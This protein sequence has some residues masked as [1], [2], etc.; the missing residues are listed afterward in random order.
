MKRQEDHRDFIFVCYSHNPQ[1]DL[2]KEMSGKKVEMEL[3]TKPEKFLLK[4]KSQPQRTGSRLFQE[5]TSGMEQ[6]TPKQ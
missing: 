6:I 2:D 4:K 5:P 1:G 3:E